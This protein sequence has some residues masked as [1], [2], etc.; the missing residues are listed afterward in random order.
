MSTRKTLDVI[1]IIKRAKIT[2]GL[3]TDTELANLLDVSQSTIAAWKS[4]GNIDFVKIITICNNVSTDWL[5]HGTGE[6]NPDAQNKDDIIEKI[7]LMLKD[8][9]MD[10]RRDV[11]KYAEKEELFKKMKELYKAKAA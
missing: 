4:R 7:T 11:L 5:L 1:K 6:M 8:M 2:L 9:D 10:Q 3:K